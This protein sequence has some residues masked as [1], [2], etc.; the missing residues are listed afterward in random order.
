VTLPLADAPAL[1]PASLRTA[2]VRLALAALAAGCVAAAFAA[3]RGPTAAPAAAGIGGA[4]VEIVLDVSGSVADRTGVAIRRALAR[5]LTG[6]HRFGLVV[7]SDVAEEVEPPGT[8]VRELGPILRYFRPLR[9][10]SFPFN[11]WALGFTGGT[12]VSAGIA[13]ARRALERRGR[14]GR[15][16]LISDLADGPLDRMPL[17]RELTAL[18]RD[19]IGFRVLPIPVTAVGALPLYRGIFGRHVVGLP[20][21][22]LRAAP[23]RGTGALPIVLIGIAAAA[24]AAL[25]AREL[26]VASLRW[27]AA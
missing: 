21:T 16:V 8:P 1:R 15:V 7:F 12:T 6:V 27:R 2:A 5:A 13:A 20:R 3:S 23:R 11:P 18:A 10:G 25:A 19:S 17:R 26:L 9:D 22:T 24:A 4:S 14:R